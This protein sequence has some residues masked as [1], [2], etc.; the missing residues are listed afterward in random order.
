ML[1]RDDVD[2][3]RQQLRDDEKV[4][5]RKLFLFHKKEQK[6]LSENCKNKLCRNAVK[7]REN[8]FLTRSRLILWK[9]IEWFQG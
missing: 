8:S 5:T 4:K 7:E 1:C 2:E 9:Q 3:K 6:K